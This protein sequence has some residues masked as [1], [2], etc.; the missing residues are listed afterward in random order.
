MSDEKIGIS[1]NGYKLIQMDNEE[2][3]KRIKKFYI[4]NENEFVHFAEDEGL[5]EN[6]VYFGFF[7]SEDTLC[8]NLLG[9]VSLEFINDY[10][11]K[12]WSTVIRKDLRGQGLGKKMNTCIQR[13][14]FSKGYGK[15]ATHVHTNNLASII[16]KLKMGFIIEGTLRNH[17]NE[18]SSEYI[19]GKRIKK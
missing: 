14:L 11:A 18:D 5:D 15:I 13:L 4:D 16:M 8:S 12:I 9:V 2:D 1:L 6:N 10:L 17:E 3:R 19:M 7:E